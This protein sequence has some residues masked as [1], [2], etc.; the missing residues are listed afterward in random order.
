MPSALDLLSEWLAEG[1]TP[2]SI[3][4]CYQMLNRQWS[5]CIR[6]SGES[7]NW[8]DGKQFTG[9]GDHPDA[10]ICAAVEKARRG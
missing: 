9:E 7:K 1:Q 2:R 3:V 4:H 6:D 5:C 8:A 10:A